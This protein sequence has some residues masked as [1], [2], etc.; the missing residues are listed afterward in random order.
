MADPVTDA[1][2]V[3][4]GADNESRLELRRDNVELA[5]HSTVTRIVLMFGTVAIDSD[6]TPAIF[7]LTETGY[8]GIKLGGQGLRAGRHYA[9]ITTFDAQHPNGEVWGKARLFEVIP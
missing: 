2:L 7:D 3:F 8:I 1:I 6:V 4:D 5:D 9:T